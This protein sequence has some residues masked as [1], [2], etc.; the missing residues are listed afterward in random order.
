MAQHTYA[1]YLLCS[2]IHKQTMRNGKRRKV[3]TYRTHRIM[4]LKTIVFCVSFAMRARQAMSVW[5]RANKCTC[6]K[7]AKRTK[8]EVIS[9]VQYWP[10]VEWSQMQH[11][12]VLL[13]LR[14]FFSIRFFFLD[15]QI[16]RC[17]VVQSTVVFCLYAM[18][19]ETDSKNKTKQNIAYDLGK[20]ARS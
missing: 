19:I 5:K 6:N 3:P 9:S 8:I 13:L 11:G 1:I 2:H 12:S 16:Q 17:C 20:C 15:I 14:V 4:D 7:Y 10:Y 18:G